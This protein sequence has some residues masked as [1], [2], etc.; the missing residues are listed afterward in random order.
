MIPGGGQSKDPS[1]ES[2]VNIVMHLHLCSEP[3]ARCSVPQGFSF[4]IETLA[5][6]GLPGRN[7]SI[8]GQ[9]QISKI[10][11]CQ[12]VSSASP[13]LTLHRSKLT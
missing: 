12:L 11:N 9:S 6:E 3:E 2:S 10:C 7:E 4:S 5:D 1:V 13:V 8:F